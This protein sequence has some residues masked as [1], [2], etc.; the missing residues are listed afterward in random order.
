MQ[1][2]KRELKPPKNIKVGAIRFKIRRKRKLLLD[3][4]PCDGYISFSDGEIFIASSP[5]NFSVEQITVLHEILHAILINTGLKTTVDIQHK[6]IEPI[7]AE[8]VHVL[9]S[10]PTL[11]RY[12]SKKTRKIQEKNKRETDK[13][14]PLRKEETSLPVENILQISESLNKPDQS[15]P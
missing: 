10:N 11:V 6:Y 5:M 3:G 4:E 15:Q 9:Q 13:D 2:K 8:L 1:K 14:V 7:S 12:L